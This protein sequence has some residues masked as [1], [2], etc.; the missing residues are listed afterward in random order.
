MA[1]GGTRI[2]FGQIGAA[3]GVRGEVRLRSFTADP[4]AIANYGPLETEDGRIVEIEALRPAKDHFVARL[5]GIVDR[6][7]AERLANLKLYVPRERLPAPDEP[8]EFYHADLIGLAA[9]DRSG[10]EIG[11]VVGI[12]NFGAGDLIEVRLGDSDKTELVAFNTANVPMV[13]IGAGQIVV[14]LFPLVGEGG[15]AKPSR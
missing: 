6:D 4:L 10:R 12:H 3:H 7:A 15:E 11:T 2:C 5:S 9:V 14:N 13:D 1:A 8:D